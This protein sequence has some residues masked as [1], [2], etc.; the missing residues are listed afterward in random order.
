MLRRVSISFIACV[1]LWACSPSGP[2]EFGPPDG[3]QADGT[4][5]W[6]GGTDTTGTL[7]NLET[8][9]AMGVVKADFV[10][11]SSPAIARQRSVRNE[12][13]KYA[14]KRELIEIFR[15]EP[16]VVDSLFEAYVV[17]LIEQATFTDNVDDDLMRLKREGYKKIRRHFR[18]PFVLTG[19][20][21]QLTH[22]DSLA[23]QGIGGRVSVQLHV[24]VEGKP[25]SI[26]LIKSVHPVL[27]DITMRVA[28][29]SEWQPAYLL[30]GGKSNPIPSWARY[31]LNFPV[32]TTR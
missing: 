25:V 26:E 28:A 15:N 21:L 1:F 23:E 6:R 13:Y 9:E 8:L 18:E 27:D 12:Q 5:W 2:Y 4:V 16:A 32:R 7:K 30:Q 29:G 3:W 20:G 22:P 10:Y 31:N 17:P 19:D 11:A 24:D 14:L